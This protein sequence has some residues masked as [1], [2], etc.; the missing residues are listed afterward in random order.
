M[1]TPTPRGAGEGRAGS[2]N[3]V[4]RV[5]KVGEGPVSAKNGATT[6]NKVPP[7]TTFAAAARIP[8]LSALLKVVQGQVRRTTPPNRPRGT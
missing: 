5:N 3:P 8:R 6:K 7:R 1:T 4:R 2:P